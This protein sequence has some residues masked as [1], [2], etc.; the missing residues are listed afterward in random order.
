MQFC[1]TIGG[2]N[3]DEMQPATMTGLHSRGNSLDS[4]ESLCV[5]TVPDSVTPPTWMFESFHGYAHNH[6]HDDHSSPLGE[7]RRTHSSLLNSN[8]GGYER[9]HKRLRLASPPRPSICPRRFFHSSSMMD[10]TV[11]VALPPD[12]HRLALPSLL[13]A[14]NRVPIRGESSSRLDNNYRLVSPPCPFGTMS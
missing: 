14:Q 5:M 11:A 9:A 10:E 8:G 12:I 13:H 4:R 3:H 2:R 6:G 7:T 1:D